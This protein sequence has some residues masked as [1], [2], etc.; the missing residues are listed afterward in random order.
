MGG[1]GL[2][3]LD[4]IITLLVHRWGATVGIAMGQKISE[5]PSNKPVL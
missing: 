4:I 2:R 1:G 5:N 3:F